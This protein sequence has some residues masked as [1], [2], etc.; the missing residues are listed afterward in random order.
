MP[1]SRPPAHERH[2]VS[3]PPLTTRAYLHAVDRTSRG[4]G[5]YE[6]TS[7]F[8]TPGALSSFVADLATHF[9]PKLPFVDAVVGLD[10]LGFVVAGALAERV[11]KPVILSRKGGKL[12]LPAEEVVSSGAFAD[13]SV[14]EKGE[15]SME[16]RRDLLREGMGVLVV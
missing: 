13:Y 15:K 8:A 2:G 3:P 12:A 5:R 4:L 7:F 10:A 6:L 11:G 16:I 1:A 14:V 9:A